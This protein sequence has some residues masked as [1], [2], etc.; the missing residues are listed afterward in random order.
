MGATVIDGKALAAATKAEA[1]EKVRELKNR[2]INPCLAVIL[3]GVN[4]ASQVYV[5]GKI[6]DCAQCGIESRSINLPADTTQDALL[7]EVKKLAD[8]SAVHGILVQLPL[9]AQIDEKAVIDAIPPEKDVDGFSPVNVGRMQIG[10]PC[11]LPCTPAGCIR[12]IE[13]TGTDI[14]GKNAVVIGR[15]NIVGKP[16]ALLLLAKNAT[17]TICHSRTKNLKEV[18]AAADI[19]VAAVGREGFVTGDMVKPGAVVIDVGINRGADGKLRELHIDKAIDVSKLTPSDT[20]DKQGKPEEIPGGTKCALASCPNFTTEK[21]VVD[22]EVE[23]DVTGDSFASLVVT[24]GSGKVVGSENEV[25][26]KPADSL[27]VP[28]GSGKIKIDGHCTV[29]KTTV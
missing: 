10:E 21:Y 16:A 11:Y 12:M 1:A 28:A 17:V 15:S 6:N 24:E 22:G 25:E 27:F 14:A 19:L 20:S 18:C 26:F 2:G 3:V 7:A 9:P 13:S 4:P 29:V 23:I 8:D 5:R